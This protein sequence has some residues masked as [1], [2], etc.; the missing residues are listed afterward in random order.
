MLLLLKWS[1]L[2]SVFFGLFCYGHVENTYLILLLICIKN[3]K[4]SAIPPNFRTRN[5]VGIRIKYIYTF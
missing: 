3:S 2:L 1:M 4:I 5:C